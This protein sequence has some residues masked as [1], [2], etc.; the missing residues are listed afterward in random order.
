MEM[1]I[2]GAVT[3]YCRTY[4]EDRQ[5]LIAGFDL[6]FALRTNGVISQDD[7]TQAYHFLNE[8]MQKD[9]AVEDGQVKLVDQKKAIE[10]FLLDHER[11]S[12]WIMKGE[13][14]VG[15]VAN[16]SKG[17]Y[18]FAMADWKEFQFFTFPRVVEFLV[19]NYQQNK[20]DTLRC[21]EDSLLIG[22]VG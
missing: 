12:L 17:E 21:G 15:H 14:E 8:T 19:T 16:H 22:S 6:L 10:R 1:S 18:Y 20:F 9:V 13:K 5:S 3:D 11:H 4:A 7:Y 2:K